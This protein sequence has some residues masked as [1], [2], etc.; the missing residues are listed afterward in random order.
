MLV[1]LPILAIA[2]AAACIWL[3]VRIVNRREKWAKKV[4]F[5]LAAVLAVGLAVA[6]PLS[7]PWANAF[8]INHPE[9]QWR[10]TNRAVTFYTPLGFVLRHCPDNL[11]D[12]YRDYCD[13]CLTIACG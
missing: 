3:A 13:W 11:R 1:L 9:L 2:L 4:A 12:N 5:C 7:F 6:Y 8:L 10:L